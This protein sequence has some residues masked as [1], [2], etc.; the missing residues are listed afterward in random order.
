[1]QFKILYQV[2]HSFYYMSYKMLR[3][4]K[5]IWERCIQRA[6]LP[7]CSILGTFL[8]I[9]L[10]DNDLGSIPRDGGVF[11]VWQVNN[12]TA[13]SLYPSHCSPLSYTPHF[14]PRYRILIRFN[15][16]DW[17]LLVKNLDFED[18]HNPWLYCFTNPLEIGTRVSLSHRQPYVLVERGDPSSSCPKFKRIS[19]TI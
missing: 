19:E 4:Y 8:M 15:G 12:S 16:L 14:S 2:Q 9:L 10:G 1:M 18:M 13:S 11:Y 3:I 17:S 5:V 6:A 7:T